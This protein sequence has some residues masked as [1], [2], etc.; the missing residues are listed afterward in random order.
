MPTPGAVTVDF[1]VGWLDPA[2]GPESLTS[3]SSISRAASI[4]WGEWM[5]PVSSRQSWRWTTWFKLRSAGWRPGRD[6]WDKLDLSGS[7]PIFPEARRILAEFGGLRFGPPHEIYDLGPSTNAEVADRLEEFGQLIQSRL[8]CVGYYEHQ[9]R[10]YFIV[11][12]DGTTYTLIEGYDE[13][14]EETSEL[15]PLASSFERLIDLFTRTAHRSETIEDL[16][17]I[18]LLGRIWF[19]THAS[20]ESK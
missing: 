10:I 6:I 12:E 11:G 4:R 14:D 13:N 9:D 15:E 18:G 16:R 2:S 8:Y 3:S 1:G 19:L 20:S 17:A 5:E 7:P